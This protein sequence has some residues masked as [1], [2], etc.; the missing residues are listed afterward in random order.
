MKR[1]MKFTAALVAVLMA[2]QV[3][4]QGTPT[5][6]L[7]IYNVGNPNM[8]SEDQDCT[9][10]PGRPYIQL[11]SSQAATVSRIRVLA[12]TVS[13]H[14]RLY[15]YGVPVYIEPGS[16]GT[17]YALSLSETM[18]TF[19]VGSWNSAGTGAAGTAICWPDDTL[20][21]GDSEVEVVLLAGSGYLVEG[22]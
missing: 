6:S 8:A 22:I 16:E 7:R 14:N 9:N 13:G 21:T 20:V 5:V 2:G 1:L 15:D 10:G 17:Q 12:Y 18:Q 4:A 3:M 11:S 19:S